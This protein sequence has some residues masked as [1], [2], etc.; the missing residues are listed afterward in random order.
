M[1]S[2]DPKESM[3]APIDSSAARVALW[4][5]AA[6]AVAGVPPPWA[7]AGRG[8]TPSAPSRRTAAA[9]PCQAA[10]CSGV[11]PYSLGRS[12][13]APAACRAVSRAVSDRAAAWCTASRRC[14]TVRRAT[15]AQAEAIGGTATNAGRTFPC[16][17]P[18]A[19]LH[20]RQWARTRK[21]S[22]RHHTHHRMLRRLTL[23][24]ACGASPPSSRAESP[25]CVYS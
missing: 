14:S 6:A 7:R 25:P 17:A 9:A 8:S 23:V 13:G 22:Y 16:R 5:L 19:R 24:L 18:G 4:P 3:S 15:A 10:S 21:F 11:K 20:T 1:S 12:R 2:S